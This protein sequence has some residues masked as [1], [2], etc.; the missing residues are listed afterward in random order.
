LQRC[1]VPTVWPRV[2][3]RLAPRGFP[4][5]HLFV[6]FDGQLLVADPTLMLWETLP[7][8]LFGA[9]VHARRQ[10]CCYVRFWRHAWAARWPWP[11]HC[12]QT[13]CRAGG[14]ACCASPWARWWLSELLPG[15]F[16]VG[17]LGGAVL[18]Q[19]RCP[20]AASSWRCCNLLIRRFGASIECVRLVWS[21]SDEFGKDIFSW[22]GGSC[23]V[24]VVS[25]VAA[26]AAPGL[27]S[28]CSVMAVPV[29]FPNQR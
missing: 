18:H 20:A 27:L 28:L 5:F 8:H 19:A 29:C 12:W 6:V 16:P 2:P 9:G 22:H 26:G 10:R 17:P 24:A 3:R 25:T 15:L 14:W 1:G 13:R 11:R 4:V 23:T 7:W 21:S